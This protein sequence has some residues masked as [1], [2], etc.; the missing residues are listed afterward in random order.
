MTGDGG[1][2][3][4][5][6][7][8]PFTCHSYGHG[9]KVGGARAMQSMAGKTAL[10]SPWLGGERGSERGQESG[11]GVIFLCGFLALPD[12]FPHT[13]MK[14]LPHLRIAVTVSD[15]LKQT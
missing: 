7:S 4:A 9:D 2:I 8:T 6:P 5:S 1:A 11:G 14:S 12:L 3:L 10:R 15:I 13:L